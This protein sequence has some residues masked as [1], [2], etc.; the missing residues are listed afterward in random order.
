M[1]EWFVS[2]KNTTTLAIDDRGMQYGDGL[3]ETVAI[4]DGRPR[5]WDYHRERLIGDCKRIGLCA[6]SEAMLDE[7]LADALE[8]TGIDTRVCTAKLIVT[9]GS[10][11]RGYR[12]QQSLGDG[13]SML[14]GIH[15]YRSL[16]VEAYA[17][18][19]VVRVC[20]LRLAE[21]PALAGVKTLNRLEQVLARNEWS[22]PEIFE[23][24][25]RDTAGRLICGTIS[26]VFLVRNHSLKTPAVDRC[27]IAGVM[28]RHILTLADEAGIDCDVG[29]VEVDDLTTANEVFLSNSQ[30]GIV[31]V[32]RCGDR[33]WQRHDLTRQLMALLAANGVTECVH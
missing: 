26:N 32:R 27:G 13:M 22:D 24:L 9:S 33:E 20:D 15:E 17:R 18:G 28:R 10:G 25:T 21:Q 23:G 31:P 3:F 8:K 12:R 5:L 19:V 4:R 6:P 1:S 11:E 16:D 7:C 2:G 30:F 14:I 29:E